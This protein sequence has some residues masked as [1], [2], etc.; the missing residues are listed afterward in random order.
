MLEQVATVHNHTAIFAAMHCVL[1]LARSSWMQE[2]S[3]IVEEK[4]KELS[5]PAP[6]S[7]EL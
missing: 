5:Y 2:A 4:E 1:L 3:V 6:V 7:K